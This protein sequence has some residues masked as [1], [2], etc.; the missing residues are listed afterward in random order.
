MRIHHTSITVSNLE[1]SQEFYEK[2]FDMEKTSEWFREEIGLHGINLKD[3]SG[4]I[5]ELIKSDNVQPKLG[6][7]NNLN[8]I[9]IKHISFSVVDVDL[10][11]NK[12]IK[13]FGAKEL[14]KPQNG[15]SVKR[16]AFITDPDGIPIELV[17]E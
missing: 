8:E 15:K 16:I 7:Y 14:W 13:N 12:A 11:F 1:K 9:G 10:V 5:L 6:N 4:M 2:L 3:E 17:G